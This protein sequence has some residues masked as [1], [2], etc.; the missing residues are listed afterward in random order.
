MKRKEA[1]KEEEKE[2]KS[3]AQKKSLVDKTK[4]TET[5]DSLVIP[6]MHVTNSRCRG[7]WLPS[8][9]HSYHRRLPTLVRCGLSAQCANRCNSM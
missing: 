8:E 9:T 3:E 7:I 6:F 4:S 1:E 2:E 5:A